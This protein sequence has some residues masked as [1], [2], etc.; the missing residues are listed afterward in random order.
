[1]IKATGE[2]A[3]V[4]AA[5]QA[6]GDVGYEWDLQG[7]RI[8][9]SEGMAGLFGTE[10][11]GPFSRGDSYNGRVNPEDLPYR[12]KCLSDHYRTRQTFDCEYRIRQADGGFCWVHDRGFAEFD[13]NGKPIRLR[14]VLRP[15]NR[16]KQHEARLEHLANFDELTGHF[17]RNRVRDA[18]HQA[19]LHGQRYGIQGAYFSIGIDKL[20]LINDAYGYLTADAVIIAV[21][22]RLERV[23]RGSDVMG[24]VGGDV[25]GLVLSHCPEEEMT[26][27][28]EKI[29]R[30]FRDHPI[31]TPSG[32]LHVSVSIGGVAYPAY[33]QTAHEA[34]THAETAMQAAKRQGRDCFNVYLLTDEQRSDQRRS[35]VVGEQI[36]AALKDHRLMFAFQP[37]VRSNGLATKLYE[38]LLRM[39]SPSG[40]IVPAGVFVPVG[41]RLGLARIIDRRVLELA[42][43]EL[44]THRQ[45][46]LAVNISGF[47]A[48]DH[49]WLRRLVALLGDR[50]E[51]ASR[52]MVEITETAAI[53]DIEETARFVATVRELGCHVALDDFGAGFTSFRHLKAL[54]VDVVKIDG[55]FIRGIADNLDNRL[56]VR[57]LVRLAKSFGLETVAECVETAED[58]E[59]LVSEGVD[60][61][62]GHHFAEPSLERPWTSDAA[63]G[64]QK[65]Y[66]RAFGA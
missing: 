41:E 47:T 42:V 5:M 63:A 8:F 15:I 40:D 62:Q 50:P 54:T 4:A 37:I 12:L 10:D 45:V 48:A 18:L 29:L 27:V 14:G 56:F 36:K 31:N 53:Q 34:I 55:S 35:M 60:Y 33:V 17:N 52:L 7:D 58:A 57:T 13:K 20:G 21:G 16:R 9:W 51:V 22:Q 24:R 30:A 32:S 6:A 3:L 38:C 61:L 59:V 28:A 1:M 66:L 26:T 46:R 25:Y 11:A 39:R 2:Q 43:E 49:S 19:L 44:T 65:R 23:I 64:R